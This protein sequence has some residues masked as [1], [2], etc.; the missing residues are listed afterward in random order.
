MTTSRLTSYDFNALFVEHSPFVWRV[1]R[2]HGVPE[3]ELEDG[4][5]DVFVVVHRRLAEFEGR[6]TLRTWIYAIAARVAISTRRKARFRRE[7]LDDAVPEQ[8]IDAPQDAGTEE[9]QSLALIMTALSMLPPARREVFALYELEGMT[10]AEV[11]GA[12]SIPESTA[13]SRLYA[14]REEIRA[15]IS[16]GERRAEGSR[17]L[18]LG[19]AL[20]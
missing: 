9:R 7:R 11:A 19:R 14:A 2:R 15:F 4:C 17:N 3:R 6:S 10:M 20:P 16:R 1:L 12:L 5:Q 8:S 13:L 18:A